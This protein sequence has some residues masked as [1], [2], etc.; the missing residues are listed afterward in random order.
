MK[1]ALL[2]GPSDLR[3]GDVPVPKIS[4]DEVLVKVKAISV[5]PSDVRTF[6]GVYKSRIFE[7]GLDSYGMSG[8]E[9]A[10]EILE[11]GPRIKHLQPGDKIVPEIII[12]CGLCKL[13]RRGLTNL[14]IRKKPV[15]RGYAEYAVA[16]GFYSYKVPKNVSIQEAALTEPVAVSIRANMRTNCLPG[17][18]VLVVGAGPMGLLNLMVA[19]K[20]GFR[21]VVSEINSERRRIAR[22][23]G[24]DAVVNPAEEKLED[25]IKSEGDGLGADGV[26]MATGAKAAIESAVKVVRPFGTV[27]LFASTYPKE[28]IVLDPNTI[29]YGEI[30]ITGSFDH[31]PVDMERALV[32]MEKK[33][34]DVMKIISK[35]FE[36]ENLEE[37]FIYWEKSAGLKPMILMSESP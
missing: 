23:L 29:H 37:A 21:V 13:C 10:G 28:D 17:D 14:C 16:K 11:V 34:I 1:A 31:L 32:F 4:D 36:L 18:L 22:E 12:P 8:H 7:Y 19:K 3:I 20:F 33:E 2:F 6:R 30:N 26:I 5:C 15:L 24:A 25:V 35:F 27:V 9:W